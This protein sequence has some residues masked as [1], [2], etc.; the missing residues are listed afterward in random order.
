MNPQVE[1]A[2]EIMQYGDLAVWLYKVVKTQCL[3]SRRESKFA[4]AEKLSLDELM[5][6][7]Q[8]AALAAAKPWPITPEEIVL[9][10]EYRDH[11]Q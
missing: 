6:S 8:E 11:L 5:P 2:L 9:R 1:K 10:G 3:L 7:H 4:P